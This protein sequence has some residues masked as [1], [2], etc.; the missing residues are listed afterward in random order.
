MRTL[1][2]I[3]FCWVVDKPRKNAKNET[4]PNVTAAERKNP[5]HVDIPDEMPF[6]LD[7]NKKS[8]TVTK[9]GR[10]ASLI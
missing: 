4:Q 3:R 10:I 6:S 7:A 5:S 8:R 9:V 1:R 2:E